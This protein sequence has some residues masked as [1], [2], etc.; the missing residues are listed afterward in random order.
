M[1]RDTSNRHERSRNT[2]KSRERPQIY[3]NTAP[4]Y[5][6]SITTFEKCFWFS[7]QSYA[8]F[9]SP[10]SQVL[11]SSTGFTFFSSTNLTNSLICFFD[12][13]NA[14]LTVHAAL[15][16]ASISNG[17]VEPPNRPVNTTTPSVLTAS[18]DCFNPIS[19]PLPEAMPNGVTGSDGTIRSS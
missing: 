11:K 15:N 7:N 17:C 16:A 2:G 18:S 14:P 12:P 6:I 19:P 4:R 5:A 13:S 1:V 8:R 3:I 9:T 10:S